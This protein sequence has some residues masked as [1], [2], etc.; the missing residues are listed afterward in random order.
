MGGDMEPSQPAGGNAEAGSGGA[1]DV[2]VL[3]RDLIIRVRGRAV[4]D[5]L[6]DVEVEGT[7][8]QLSRRGS[9]AAETVA[10]S[11]R[12]REIARLVAE[13]HANKT[14][15]SSLHISAWTVNTHLRRVFAKL[16]VSSRTAMVA[17]LGAPEPSTPAATAEEAARSPR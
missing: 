8:Y 1:E 6:L 4:G 15:A 7:H 2:E 16:G 3:A 10:L 12:E 17:R 13:G 14:I 9:D 5:V 11:P